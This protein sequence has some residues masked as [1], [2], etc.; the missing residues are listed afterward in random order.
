[1]SL[2]NC[3]TQRAWLVPDDKREDYFALVDLVV[4][5]NPKIFKTSDSDCAW[6]PE[7][8]PIVIVDFA[9]FSEFWTKVITSRFKKMG[10]KDITETL[11]A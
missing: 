11:I 9:Y 5:Y 7:N 8:D 2:I 3:D 10:A 6:G 4:L 1:M